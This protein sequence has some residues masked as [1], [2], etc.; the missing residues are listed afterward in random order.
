M[1]FERLKP[2]SSLDKDRINQLKQLLP[3]AFA[4]GKINWDILKEILDE[5]LEDIGN[6]AEHF[7]L[8]WPGKKNARR[9]ATVPSKGTL[10]PVVGEGINED[11]TK[12]IFIEGDNLEVL[13]LLQK[14][15]VSRIKMIYIDPPYNTGRDFIYKDNFEE[16]LQN[17]LKK[18]GQTDEEGNLLTT[19]ARTDGRFHSNWLSM[20][21]P[22]LRLARTLLKEEGV[23]FVSIAD[24]EIHNLRQMMNEIF[25]EEN[26]VATIIWQ[27]NFSPKNTARHFS[28][29]HEYIVVYAKNADIWVPQVLPRTE[30]ADARY[31]NLDN[32]PRGVW[33]SSD[34]TARNYY[35]E[36]QYEVISPNGKAFKPSVGNYWRVRYEKFLELDKDNRIWWGVSKN[37]MPRFKRFL[38]DVKQGVVP[39][40][41]WKHEDVGHTQEAKKEL[42]EFVKFENTD[43]VLDTVKPTRLIQRILQI[44]TSTVED[45][46]ILDFFAGS[47]TTGHAVLKQNISD[48]GTRQFISIQIPEKLPTSEKQI[49]TIADI[50]K[51]RLRNVKK[52]LEKE[53][54][55]KLN[56]RDEGKLLED[57]G[58]K[59]FKLNTS[60]FKLWQ[61]YQGENTRQLQDLFSN[62]E[63]PLTE[64]WQ[65]KD[66]LIE[67]MLLEGFPLSSSI[68]AFTECVKNTVYLISSSFCAHK[69][70]VCLESEIWEETIT[71]VSEL[72][73]GDIFICLDNALTDR[74]KTDL[75]NK[76][77]LKTI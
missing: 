11:T 62:F 25:G 55:E 68:S 40:T 27:K 14:S 33:S 44:G 5:Q 43:N 32:D 38:S 7:G 34:L 51:E 53:E 73:E 17:Y 45:D 46:I 54:K 31:T 28:E 77:N 18:T 1:P 13:K 57:L 26:F 37:N 3:E 50:G 4:D 47:S 41:L 66:I 75:A 69:L 58:F 71:Q 12:N 19:N 20:M 10:V 49:K 65:E 52:Q 22:R 8:T 74:D 23:I 72:A 76:C 63:S 61:D 6:D 16:S 36:G 42:L 24:Q 48:G 70:Y 60:N 67:L 35:S 2:A 64:E 59:V 9:L 15:Y 56:F 21:Y 39:Q 29:D 30:E